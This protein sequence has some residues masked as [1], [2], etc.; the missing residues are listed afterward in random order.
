MTTLIKEFF[1]EAYKTR[2]FADWSIHDKVRKVAKAAT[3]K[4][5]MAKRPPPK[6]EWEAYLRRS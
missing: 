1:S 3:L 4:R 2:S 5:N 6:D